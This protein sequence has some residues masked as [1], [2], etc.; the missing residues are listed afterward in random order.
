MGFQQRDANAGAKER[1]IQCRRDYR[2]KVKMLWTGIERKKQGDAANNKYDD[3]D[4]EAIGILRINAGH[5]QTEGPK[6]ELDCRPE[7]R[8]FPI[9]L[10]DV[11]PNFFIAILEDTSK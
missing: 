3:I 10:Q 7:N 6:D 2:Y 11:F 8:G 4:G 9:I 1:Y 5:D